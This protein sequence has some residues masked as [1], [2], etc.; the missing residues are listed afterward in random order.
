MHVKEP[1]PSEYDMIREDQ[2]VFT[3]LH[4]AADEQQTKALIKSKS[5]CIAYE[6]IEKANGSLPLLVPMSE[7][8]G[9]MGCAGSC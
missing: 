5:V 7:V 3:Y 2:I 9:R 8:A 4:L 1:Q 6:T